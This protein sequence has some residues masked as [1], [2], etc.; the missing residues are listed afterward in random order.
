MFAGRLNAKGP[1]AKGSEHSREF[2]A[3]TKAIAQVDQL[4][5]TVA[6]PN[7]FLGLTYAKCRTTL[8][9]IQARNTEALQKIYRDS[10]A[11]GDSQGLDLLKQT[12]ECEL[13]AATIVDFISALHDRDASADT[14][15]KTITDAREQNVTIP[16][17]SDKICRA[18]K[19][20]ELTKDGDWDT[21]FSLIDESE[22]VAMFGTD[23]QEAILDFQASSLLSATRSILMKEVK[24]EDPALG[25]AKSDDEKAALKDKLNDFQLKLMVGALDFIKA[26]F[27]N[28]VFQLMNGQSTVSQ[29]L[30]D[31][32]KL[33][34]VLT[35]AC[36]TKGQRLTEP[37]VEDVKA[38]RAHLLSN[39]KGLF[40]EALSLFPLGQLISSRAGDLVQEFHRDK[41][42]VSELSAVVTACGGLKSF[43]IDI[44]LK[45]HVKDD[46]TE[47]EIQIP[48]PVKVFDVVSKF[49]GLRC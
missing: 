14:L 17:D 37:E 16:I 8:D 31:L 3:T 7:T 19:L 42:L 9:K 35:A 21:Y 38:A 26:F 44:L 6:N 24:S 33:K 30:E 20:I 41:G 47:L 12:R 45:K 32:R 40:Y 18:R 23:D 11:N 39:R 34:I 46:V 29:L 25:D 5:S 22:L 36:A 28:K 2:E 1:K 43:T 27:N 48:N 13:Q 10:S 15:H 4:K 49:F